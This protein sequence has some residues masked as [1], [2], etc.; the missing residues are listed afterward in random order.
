MRG[1]IDEETGEVSF[2]FR[3]EELR[4]AIYEAE[5]LAAMLE[6]S[7]YKMEKLWKFAL[8][9]RGLNSDKNGQPFFADIN[10]H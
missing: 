10:G 4:L 6:N 2:H 5:H 1:H 3:P 7:G 9:L 8:D